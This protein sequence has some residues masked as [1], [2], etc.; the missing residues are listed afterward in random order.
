MKKIVSF[1]KD[2]IEELKTNV[3]WP[4]YSVLQSSSLV[5]LIASLLFAL[6]IGV[7]DYVFREGVGLLY[8]L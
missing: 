7:I 8:N 3:D 2:S 6:I 1:V 4:K 5:V